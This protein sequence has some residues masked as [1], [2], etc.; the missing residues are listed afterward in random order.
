MYSLERAVEQVSRWPS[1]KDKERARLAGWVDELVGHCQQAKKLWEGYLASPGPAGNSFAL[2]S[3]IGSERTRQLHEINLAAREVLLQLTA[4]A[5]PAAGRFAGLD[6]DVIEMAYRQIQP[7]ETG[8][9]AATK[10]VARL[11]DQIA[12]LGSLRQRLIAKGKPAP[13]AGKKKPVGKKMKT[14]AKP[15]KPVKKPAKKTK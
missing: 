4:A 15:K 10:A 8:T 6:Q 9:E 7:Q 3:W 11:N 12:Y 1:S 5:G 2:M 14:A 13:A